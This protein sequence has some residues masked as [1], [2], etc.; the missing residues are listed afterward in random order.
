MSDATLLLRDM[1]GDAAQNA[2]TKINPSEDQLSR[3]DHPAE[4]NTWHEVPSVAELKGQAKDIYGKNK[5]LS[6]QDLKDASGDATQ[7]AH[8][9]GARDPADTAAIAAQDQ[10]QGT[11]SGVS[12]QGGA[13]TGADSLQAK[14]KQNVP[15]ETQDNASELAKT[16]RLQ[17]RQYLNKKVPKERRD[18]TIWRLKKMVVEIQG[19][20]DCKFRKSFY[21]V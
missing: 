17:T 18:Q 1:A 8:P 4:D 19:H 11:S 14:A 20:E 15:Q 6:K 16:T 10:R 12:A 13:Q 21:S 2:A 7:A 3:I 9:T 5:P